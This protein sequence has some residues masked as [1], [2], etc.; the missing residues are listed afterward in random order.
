[1]KFFNFYNILFI[2]LRIIILILLLFN[3]PTSQEIVENT[4]ILPVDCNLESQKKQSILKYLLKD[5]D[6]SSTPSNHSNQRVMVQS[7]VTIQDIGSI[8]EITSSF[9]VDLWFSQIW[10]DPR[11]RYSHLSCKS[12]FSLDESVANK[13]WSPNICFVNSKDTYIHSSPESN[14]LLIIYPNGTV[15]LNHR[16]RVHGRCNMRLENFPLDTQQCKLVMESCCYSISDVRLNW[17]S[18]SP[19]TIA[20]SR[21]Q[22]PDFRFLYLNHSS[23]IHNTATGSWDQLELTF[24]FKRLYGYYILQAYLPSYLSV[25]IS[26]I[27]FWID[28]KALPA[29]I[30]L[31]VNSL[32]ALT[33]QMGNVVKNLPRVS[34]VKAIDL[35][36]FVCVIFIFCSLCELAIVGVIDNIHDKKLKKKLKLE[37]KLRALVVGH[38]SDG[39][40]VGLREG[41]SQKRPSTTRTIYSHRLLENPDPWHLCEQYK[42]GYIGH[43][44]DFY[45][46]RAFP[47]IFAAFNIFYWTYYLTRSQQ[48]IDEI[49]TN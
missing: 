45:C 47:T 42:D 38:A 4:D 17:Q 26:W 23:S 6:K 3:P 49:M 39:V 1:M 40:M 31:G 34:Y 36:F 21:F 35:W 46:A 13:L 37:R 33:F 10:E 12:N 44:I 20:N 41:L 9:I 7:E 14:I 43:K 18:W 19:V 28:S 32:M 29:R 11:L 2:I 25:F 15:W 5:Y 27:A 22:L 16:M 8:S 24:T 30:I 48:T